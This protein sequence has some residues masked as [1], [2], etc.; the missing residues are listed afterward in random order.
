MVTAIVDSVQQQPARLLQAGFTANSK[1][2]ISIGKSYE[3]HAIHVDAEIVWYQILCDVDMIVW[4][5]SDFFKIVDGSLPTDWRVNCLGED[6]RLA[7]GP[8]FMVSSHQALVDMLE[9]TPEQSNR[10]WK[11]LGRK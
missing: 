10:F 9:Q 8:E 7:I 3:V 4:L 5:P 6:A 1:L 11:R 2:Y